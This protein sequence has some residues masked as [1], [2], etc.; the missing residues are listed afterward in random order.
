L[1]EHAMAI[2]KSDSHY[3]VSIEFF[4]YFQPHFTVS[5]SKKSKKYIL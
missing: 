2:A 3:F 5:C 1:H 4:R